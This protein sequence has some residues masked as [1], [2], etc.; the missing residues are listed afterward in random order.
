MLSFDEK[1]V[2]Y[3]KLLLTAGLN[4]QEGQIVNIGMECCHRD[5]GIIL[6]EQAYKMGAK[7]VNLDLNDPRTSKARILNAQSDDYF[8]YVP[9]YITTKYY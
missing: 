6:V 5:F 9:E 8:D 4:V 7:F 3:A 1:L 2:N